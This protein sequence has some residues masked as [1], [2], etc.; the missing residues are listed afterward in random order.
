MRLIQLYLYVE[1]DTAGIGM[2]K[3]YN[4]LL[5]VDRFGKEKL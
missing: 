1:Y 3:V 2:L 4:M 5:V